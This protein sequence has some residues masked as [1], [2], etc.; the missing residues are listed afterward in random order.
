MKPWQKV[1]LG[2][3]ITAFVAAGFGIWGLLRF[4]A[5]LYPLAP[6]MPAVVSEPMPQILA[7][8]ESVLKTNVPYVST[9]LQPGLSAERISKLEQQYH[10]QLPEEIKAIYQWHNGSVSD[11]NRL[12]DFIPIHRFLPLEEALEDR[13]ALAPQKVSFTQRIAY[14]L[15]VSHRE[16]WVCLFDDGAGDGYW[17]DLKRKPAQGAIF[18]NFTEEASYTFFPSAKNLMAGL[19]ECY[20]QGAF[21]IKKDSSPPELEED[22][23]QA[24][25]IWSQ[26]G[27]SR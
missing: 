9:N 6:Q 8:L 14:R 26:F 21:H 1:I 15:L 12:I 13:A 4:R 17:F 24:Q 16:S 20:A 10:V 27:A 19:V 7:R 18:Y 23:E 11:T 22:F 3:A 5:F 2:I 25:K